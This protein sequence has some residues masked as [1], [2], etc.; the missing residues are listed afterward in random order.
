MAHIQERVRFWGDTRPNGPMLSSEPD[1]LAQTIMNERREGL[2]GR[3]SHTSSQC[4]SRRRA[5]FAAALGAATL[6]L[7]ISVAPADAIVANI[8]GHSYGVTPIRGVNPLSIPGA[9]RAPAASGASGA[10]GPRNFDGPPE[11]GGL[12]LNH[13]GPVMH[14]VTTHV[15]YWDPPTSQFTVTTKGIVSKFFTDV[16]HDKE[17]ASNVFAVA[18]QYKDATGHAAYTSTFGTEGTDA[19]AYPETGNCTIPVASGVDAGPPYTTCLFDSQLKTELSAYISANSLPTGPTQQYFV[20]LPHKVVTCFNQ[21]IKEEEENGPICSNNVYCAYHSSISPKSPNEIIYSDIPFSLLDTAFVKGCQDDGH[22]ANVQLPNG[23]GAGGNETTKYAD[24]A[25]KYTSHEYTEAA[26]DPLGNAY[27]DTHGLENGDKCNGVSFFEPNGVG[28]DKNAFLPT[29]G[30]VA[31]SGTLF[32]QL[33]NA[34]SY[35]LQ[36]EWDNAAK[37][38]LMKPVAL[39]SAG[40]TTSPTSGLVGAPM[41]FKGAAT[42]LYAGLSFTWKWGDG[43][44]SPGATPEPQ[45]RGA[46]QLRSDDD[47]QG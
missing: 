40:F 22:N 11:G 21:T 24:V 28:Y 10:T 12:L 43:T 35:Y 19:T 26:T 9:Y 4:H 5:G 8:G 38:C 14:S 1:S 7:S 32:D 47:T 16:A 20:L 30:G 23:D 34:D 29:L 15:I 46:R 17:L 3:G 2:A 25:L 27:F 31:G 37:A 18:G 41:E 44:E 13:G 33:I 36:S 42:D 45:L 39:S 6:A